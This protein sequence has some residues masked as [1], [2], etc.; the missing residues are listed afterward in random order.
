MINLINGY[1][2]RG[3]LFTKTNPVRTRRTYTPS[4]S[5]E[6]FGLITDDLEKEF[7]AGNEIGIGKAKLK[8]I[9]AHLE[10][11]YCQ[12]VRVEFMYIRQPERMSWLRTKMES[13]RNS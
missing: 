10:E 9:I 13:T 11:I 12:S 1:R 3:H 8:E 5:I 6:N 2:Q 7:Q 4:L